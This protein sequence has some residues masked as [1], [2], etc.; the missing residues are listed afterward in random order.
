MLPETLLF[1]VSSKSGRACLLDVLDLVF[2][3]ANHL[4]VCLKHVQSIKNLE[5]FK[6]NLSLD[7]LVLALPEFLQKEVVDP[8]L[9]KI[10]ELRL[11]SNLERV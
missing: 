2:E 3:V 11:S 6:T 7:K 9:G 4:Q 5:S 10:R 1:L 8:V